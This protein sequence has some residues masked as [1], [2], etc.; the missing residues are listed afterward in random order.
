MDSKSIENWKTFVTQNGRTII[1]CYTNAA[2]IVT[3]K[4]KCTS[5]AYN[6]KTTT[7]SACCQRVQP[8]LRCLCHHFKNIILQVKMK[9]QLYIQSI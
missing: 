1:V 2:N 5:S 4:L 6:A 7:S 9:V 3:S 8:S